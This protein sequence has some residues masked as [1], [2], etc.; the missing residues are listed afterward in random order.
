MSKL[1]KNASTRT[2]NV[3][4]EADAG[5]RPLTA[6]LLQEF[7][8]LKDNLNKFK[9]EDDNQD[10]GLC[11]FKGYIIFIFKILKFDIFSSSTESPYQHLEKATVL[12]DSRAFHDAAV[13]TQNPRK[14]CTLITKLLFLLIKGDSFSSTE[15]TDVFFGV[16]KL[17]QSDDV[18]LRRMMYLFIKEV[19][20][21][22]NPDDVIIVTSSLTKDMNTGEDLYR[23]NSMRVLAKI[24]D[25]TMLGAI[26][27]YLKQA[28]V[29]RNAFVASSALMA[30]LNLFATCPE[31]VRRWIN[32]V[33]E[34]VNSSSD[35]VQYHALSLLYKIK[36]HDRLA[37]SKVVQQLSKGSLRSPLATCLLIRYTNSLMNEDTS[38][39]NARAGYQFLESCLRHK[40]DMVRNILKKVD[41]NFQLTTIYYSYYY[42]LTWAF[43]LFSRQPKLFATC[44][45]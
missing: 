18:N 19:A 45:L 3:V 33:Q 34:A 13:V 25:A 42:Y 5:N 1:G 4:E 28:I 17:F 22:C 15:V 37:V 24:I 21:T 36:Q 10:R 16:T 26:E 2:A 29:D 40:N 14:C 9:N 30:G 8:N 27:R 38:A 20:E 12:Q 11:D 23:A 39:T 43:R 6:T 41:K 35:M 32:E 31:V 7:Q 44:Q